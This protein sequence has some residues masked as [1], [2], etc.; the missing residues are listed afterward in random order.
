MLKMYV[1]GK[2]LEPVG[3][4]AQMGR[5][6]NEEILCVT[7]KSADQMETAVK[8]FEDLTDDSTV[9]LENEKKKM[10]YTWYTV[11][12]DEVVARKN[13]DGTYTYSVRLKKKSALEVAKQA[14]A[15]VEYLAAVTGV[16][17]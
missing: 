1:N 15:D 7:F 3:L 11:L 13:T 12:D 2:E 8:V 6:D 14:A 4:V 17:L 5:L 10:R 9:I 16:E